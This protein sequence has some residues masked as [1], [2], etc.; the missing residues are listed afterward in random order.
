MRILLLGK[1][2]QVGSELKHTL[3]Q[4][5]D[6]TA[7]DST[8][9]DDVC[10]DLADLDGLRHAVRF[11]KPDV[12]VNAAA[13]NAVDKAETEKELAHLINAIAPQVMAEEMSRLGGWL[14]HY[15]TDYVFDGSGN[16]PWQETDTASP[17]NYYG[18]TKLA[19][20]K[21]IKEVNCKHLIL[22]TSWVYGVKGDN[23]AK[24]MLQLARDRKLMSVIDDQVGAP[25][26]AQLLSDM[27][28]HAISHAMKLRE[29]SG[30]YHLTA[31][32]Q[33]TWYEYAR[34]VIEQARNGGVELQVTDIKPIPTSAY[35]TPTRRPLNSRL[36]TGK[37]QKTFSCTLPGWQDGVSTLV[38]QIIGE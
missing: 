3:A 29:L 8:G 36:D 17:L 16:R 32:G 21:A 30:I 15:S 34:Y 26:G 13:Y 1:N 14:V 9:K 10:G 18:Q 28:A 11:L 35:P 25:T 38:D 33:T 4:L 20:E 12:L 2:G 27:T 37:F 19:G 22:R 23:F 7:L 31:A 5:G 6:L 24:T